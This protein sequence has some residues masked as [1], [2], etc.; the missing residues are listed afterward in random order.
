LDIIDSSLESIL[1]NFFFFLIEYPYLT[2]THKDTKII[3][4]S[5]IST[6][7][8]CTAHFDNSQPIRY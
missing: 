6:V 5:P 3:I 8:K 7:T 4:R 1:N 2:P